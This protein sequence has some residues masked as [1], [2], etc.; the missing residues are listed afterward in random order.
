MTRR[1]PPRRIS[2]RQVPRPAP[3]EGRRLRHLLARA[4][5]AMGIPRC[6]LRIRVVGDREMARWHRDYLGVEGTTTVLSFPEGA[7][8][9]GAPERLSG[10]LL[11]SAPACLAQT[12][13]WKASPEERVLFFLVHGM[14]HLAGHDHT[15]GAAQAARMR[16]EEDRVWRAAVTP[17]EGEP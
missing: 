17:A 2:L 12:R 15:R 7:T 8:S 9:G 14:L 3:L 1:S 11:V 13:G 6:D 4:L 10:D 5:D 16:R